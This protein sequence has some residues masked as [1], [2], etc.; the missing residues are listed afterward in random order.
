V[1]DDLLCYI[2]G[3]GHVTLSYAIALTTDVWVKTPMASNMLLCNDLPVF[4]VDESQTVKHIILSL[5]AAGHKTPDC[6]TALSTIL[7]EKQ[8][9]CSI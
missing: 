8:L 5:L 1:T 2:T 3:A 7:S 4:C 6:V 9:N